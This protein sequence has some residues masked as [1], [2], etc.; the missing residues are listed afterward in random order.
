[1]QN[2][3]LSDPW[4]RIPTNSQQSIGFTA[5]LAPHDN[6][7]FLKARSRLFPSSARTTSKTDDWKLKEGYPIEVSLASDTGGVGL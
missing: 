1:M 7:T 3:S 6:G 2:E 5:V 4:P